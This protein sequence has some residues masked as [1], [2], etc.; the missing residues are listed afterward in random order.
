MKILYCE[1]NNLLSHG[2][3]KSYLLFRKWNCEN[4][5]EETTMSFVSS[6]FQK[7]NTIRNV[8]KNLWIKS[9]TDKK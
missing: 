6:F 3:I 4:L 5:I 1:I 2:S 9:V 8:R 7:R